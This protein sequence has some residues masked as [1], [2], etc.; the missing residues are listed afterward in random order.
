MRKPQFWLGMAVMVPTLIWYI[1]FQFGPVLESFLFSAVFVRLLDIVHSRYVGLSNYDQLFD[2][3]LNPNVAPALTHTVIW[4][5][6]EY[7]Y[8]LPL[9]LLLATCLVNIARG[10]VLF[11][12]V[13][14]LPVITP[15]VTVGLL[16]GRLFDP[17]TGLVNQA[18][19]AVGLP[20]SQWLHDPNMALPLAAGISAWRWLGL[21]TILFTAAMLTIPREVSDAARVDGAGAWTLFRRITLPLLGHVLTLVLILLL[22]NSVQEYT[23]PAL[24]DATTG[25]YPD[26]LL[27]INQV[28]VNIG[29]GDLELGVG[30]A[31]AV[32]EC[33]ATLAG[34]LLILSIFRPRWSY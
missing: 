16:M 15:L 4:T 22:V 27:M 2:P 12:V 7:V 19:Q 23:L 32:L 3:I 34:S 28:L 1:L 29:L 10:R 21:Y 20:G 31:M 17:R 33:A 13:L 24:L 8:V 11:Q 26:P 9:S 18:L 30:S 6:L 5:L 25:Y 14:F